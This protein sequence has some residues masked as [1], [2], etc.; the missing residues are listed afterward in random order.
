MVSEMDF[1]GKMVELLEDGMECMNQVQCIFFTWN[2]F[3]N[4]DGDEDRAMALAEQV[5][6]MAFP[7]GTPEERL[8]FISELASVIQ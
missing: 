2:E 7:E 3:F 6:D 8:E 1:I 5:Y 4:D